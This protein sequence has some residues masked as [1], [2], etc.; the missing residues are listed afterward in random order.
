MD[1]SAQ[2]GDEV[3][4]AQLESALSAGLEAGELSD[5]TVSA[6]VGQSQML[7]KMRESIPEA[8]KHE[9]V[10]FK[11]DISVPVSRVPEFLER[12]ELDL[13][14]TFP[15]LRMFTFGHLGDGNLHFNPLLAEGATA[16]PNT[17]QKINMAVHDLVTA[18]GGSI[19][20]EHGIGR[21]RREELLRYKSTVEL[22]TMAAFKRLLDPQ[23]IM[24]PGKV[25]S[26]S[27][28]M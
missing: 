19:S 6:S 28:L 24:N 21:L 1:V 12:I 22:L 26:P 16:T 7:W 9:G 13:E 25:L 23:N 14:K 3:I 15:G 20:A 18:M 10:S 2:S 4:R 11:H 8:H 5:A 17:L 27:L